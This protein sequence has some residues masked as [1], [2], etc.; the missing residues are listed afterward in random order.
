MEMQGLSS[1]CEPE[2]HPEDNDF[3][4]AGNLCHLMSEPDDLR[5]IENISGSL[6]LVNREHVI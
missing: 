4:Q 1:Y 2:H 6:P 5:L 3:G